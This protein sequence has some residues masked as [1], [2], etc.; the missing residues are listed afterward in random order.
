MGLDPKT[1]D[2][3]STLG[4]TLSNSLFT[5]SFAH[6]KPAT[7]APIALEVSPDL[8]N[9]SSAATTQSLDLGLTETLTHQELASAP[10]GFFRLKC[11]LQ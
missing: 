1:P 6:F 11:S 5:L 10:A 9:W 7:D 4:A 8:V 2:P 3:A